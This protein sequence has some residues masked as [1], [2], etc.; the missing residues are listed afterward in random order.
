VIITH[1][2]SSTLLTLLQLRFTQ[3]PKLVYLGG[4]ALGYALCK[5]Y[6][7]AD[8]RT[9]ANG[10]LCGCGVD[11]DEANAWIIRTSIML[12]VTKVTNPGLQSR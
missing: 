7:P 10:I 2:R 5:L 6:S 12:S 4:F 9:A 3:L 1:H 8:D 11:L